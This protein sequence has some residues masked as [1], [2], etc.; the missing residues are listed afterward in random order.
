MWSF[1]RCL[2]DHFQFPSLSL[3]SHGP[4]P[5]AGNAE[6]RNEITTRGRRSACVPPK[7]PTLA[8]RERTNCTLQDEYKSQRLI[9]RITRW[10]TVL[11]SDFVDNRYYAFIDRSPSPCHEIYIIPRWKFS[12]ARFRIIHGGDGDGKCCRS[13]AIN[14]HGAGNNN[15]MME[16]EFPWIFRGCCLT[17]RNWQ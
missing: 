8:L 10:I 7:I 9:M 2:L 4:D 17:L 15:G 5:G 12:G 14:R 11:R 3:H 6:T 13:R 16:S 1:I